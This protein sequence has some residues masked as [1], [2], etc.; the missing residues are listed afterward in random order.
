MINRKNKKIF[1][2]I[3]LALL[4]LIVAF[5]GLKLP[6]AISI[7]IPLSSNLAGCS[8]S[9]INTLSQSNVDIVGDG[10]RIKLFV[11]S[12]G[13]ECLQLAFSQSQFDQIVQSKNIGTATKP[14]YASLAL[15][16]Y[17]K[18]FTINPT[19]NVYRKVQTNRVLDGSAGISADPLQYC[20]SHG[21]P[22]TIF[23]Y[24]PYG[25]ALYN[26]R[27]VVTQ[28]N[29]LEGGFGGTHEDFKEGK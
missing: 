9:Q 17:T 2:G 22:N 16:S 13:S 4:I 15:N 28:D 7:P 12:G 10:N 14:I 23:A 8:G 21:Y 26:Y 20:Q 3:I 18:T 11:R 19:G 29:G 24:R 25:L 27:C 5:N 1:I 6:F